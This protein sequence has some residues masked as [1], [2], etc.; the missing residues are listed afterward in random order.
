MRER[1]DSEPAST[2]GA[3]VGVVGAGTMGAGVA[4][5]FA[6][7]GYSVV[8]VDPDPE[9]LGGGPAR[10][11][12][13]VRMARLLRRRSSPS[14]GSGTA[15]GAGTPAPS[16]PSPEERVVW[17]E[18]LSDLA[19]AFF[20]VECAREKVPVKEEVLRQLD[21][22]CGPDT[23]FASCT[24]CIPITRL[25]SFTGRP[26]RV[27]GT[28]FMNPAPLKDAVEVIRAPGTSEQTVQRTVDLLAELG[29][30][31]LVVR[32]APGFVTNRVLMLTLNEAATVL[33]EGTADAETVDRIFQDCFGHPMGPLRTA[34]LI[35][36]DT[37][38]DSLDVLREFTGDERF[39]PC[40]LL[41][42]HVAE[43]SVGRK[44]GRGFYQYPEQRQRPEHHLVSRG[45]ASHG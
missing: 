15:A 34:D 40:A 41:A 25:G 17:S 18:K 42:R 12:A 26:D 44:S 31:A 32:D 16:S 20:V 14:T 19:P 36:L 21:Q 23:V 24:S 43:G 7:A 4:Q 45:G 10:L 22:V 37:V 6:E 11:R 8:V 35:G 3:P 29:K 27:I 28:H 33:G 2:T 39:R 9:A 30:R 5:C 13:G 1:K 38:L